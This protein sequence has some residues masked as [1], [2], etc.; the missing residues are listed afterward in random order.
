MAA[1]DGMIGFFSAALRMHGKEPNKDVWLVGYDNMWDDLEFRQ[2]EPLGPVATVDKK[3]LEIGHHLMSILKERIDGK[4][5]KEAEH[6]I[7]KPEL[8]IRPSAFP[9]KQ[10]TLPVVEQID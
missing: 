6:R 7:V 5:F 8:I 3:N 9:D 10:S 1:S 2:W 4:I